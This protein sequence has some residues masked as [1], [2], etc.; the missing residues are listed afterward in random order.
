MDGLSEFFLQVYAVAEKD[1][2]RAGKQYDRLRVGRGEGDEA[3]NE[4]GPA[5]NTA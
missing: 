2:S 3:A 1:E 5:A 4:V